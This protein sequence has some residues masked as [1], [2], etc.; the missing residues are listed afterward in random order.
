MELETPDTHYL[1][2]PFT[3]K[4]VYPLRTF[5][6]SRY[7]VL[8]FLSHLPL[9]NTCRLCGSSSAWAVSEAPTVTS[10][11]ERRRHRVKG[12][13][14][15]CKSRHWFPKIFQIYWVKGD[16]LLKLTRSLRFTMA[17]RKSSTA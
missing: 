2:Q 6:P 11:C 7:K 14:Y 13:C 8:P 4:A 9:S 16:T 1:D 10:G 15:K 17:A 5:F 12:K 3:W